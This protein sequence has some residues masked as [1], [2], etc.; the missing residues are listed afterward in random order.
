MSLAEK[1]AW[2]K[3]G[4]PVSQAG[5]WVPHSLYPWQADVLRHGA[6][7]GSRL[8]VVTPNE[9][10]KT[11]A[12]IPALGLAFMAAF[13]G[14]QVVSTAGVERQIRENLW[15]CLKAP[16]RKYP[17]WKVK[18]D[19]LKI[20]APSID[21]LP[22]AT[23]QA[24]TTKDPEFAEGFHERTFE[25]KRGEKVEAPLMVFIDEAKSVSDEM[26]HSF[27]RC[28]PTFWVV[29]STPGEDTGSFFQC[30][31]SAKGKPWDTIEVGWEDCPHLRTGRKLQ[32][33]LDLIEQRGEN[34][35]MVLS[36]V[37]GKFFRA[38]SR[39]IFSDM[40]AIRDCMSGMSRIRLGTR[41]AALDFSAGG[42]EAVFMARDGNTVVRI[43][44]FHLKDTMELARKFVGLIRHY[45]I[46]PE[47][48]VGDN[49]GLGKP[50]I[51]RME[52]LGV[53]GIRR[54]MADADPRDKS[55]YVN[56]IAEDHFSVQNLFTKRLLSVPEDAI[57]LEQIR[58]RQYIMKNDDSNRIRCEPKEKMRDRG[59][60]SPDRLDTLVMLFADFPAP[61]IGE[62]RTERYSQRI[63]G[64]PRE[65]LKR[66]EDEETSVFAT[67]SFGE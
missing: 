62:E 30:F 46:E 14:G 10:G 67:T 7:P 61:S 2:P 50:V 65:C 9:S 33:R 17:R 64:D 5:I 23:W 6:L 45:E 15:P 51:D 12:V 54:Y 29:I 42:D 34:D 36:W 13:P 25:N 31:H 55:L 57:L 11:S 26:F 60:K 8:A 16:L 49:G 20:E 66:Q 58:R 37:F 19:D 52:E 38:A 39:P 28:D 63:C 18:D 41:K 53:L 24:F 56:R 4:D 48:V 3:Y 59:E 47:N 40:D 43:A 27:R 35:P 1:F 22:P 32:E 44:A 21:G